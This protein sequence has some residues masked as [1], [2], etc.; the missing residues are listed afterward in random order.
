M[1]PVRESDIPEEVVAR[2]LEELAQLDRMMRALRE[3][4]FVD[5][6]T[7]VRDG[8]PPGWDPPSA[9]PSRES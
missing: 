6:P 7:E 5:R 2:R 8:P 1:K 4:R 3:V 9:R